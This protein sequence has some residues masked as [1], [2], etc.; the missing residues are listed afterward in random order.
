MENSSN[1][2]ASIEIRQIIYFLTKEKK[3]A[4]LMALDFLNKTIK[5]NK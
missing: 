3:D 1:S 4:N 5:S 2:E